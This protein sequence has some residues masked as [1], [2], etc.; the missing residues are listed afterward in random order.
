[1]KIQKVKFPV[2]YEECQMESSTYDILQRYKFLPKILKRT[3]VTPLNIKR[4]RF[5]GPRSGNVLGIGVEVA[6]TIYNFYQQHDW[7]G[8]FMD[9]PPETFSHT[10]RPFQ[11]LP[12]VD[13]IMSSEN[14]GND[15][16]DWGWGIWDFRL[17]GSVIHVPNTKFNPDSRA[18][19]M[20]ML[21]IDPNEILNA[22]T[23]IDHLITSYPEVFRDDNDDD[24]EGDDDY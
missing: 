2:Q 4:V 11:Q 10:T 24:Y 7:E 14:P 20:K 9:V 3:P 6:G 5:V 22:K 1:M 12:T 19:S 21:R 8:V 18:G 17:K 15:S 23:N 16:E 13:I